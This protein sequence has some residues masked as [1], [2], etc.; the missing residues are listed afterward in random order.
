MEENNC[1]RGAQSR[2]PLVG[3]GDQN[4]IRKEALAAGR[5]APGLQAHSSMRKCLDNSWPDASHFQHLVLSFPNRDGKG[6]SAPASSF[7]S[8]TQRAPILPGAYPK[9]AL[10][11]HL[12]AH[13]SCR[14]T[15]PAPAAQ[16]RS[17]V[18][19]KACELVVIEALGSVGGTDARC[20]R[21]PPSSV[22]YALRSEERRVG[23]ECRSRW[24]PY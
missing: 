20:S 2:L 15:G 13:R 12:A 18:S 10:H 1:N 19:R 8:Q 23:K 17:A 7:A 21:S 16:A 4:L 3:S 22:S 11:G 24:A 6:V 5:F 14:T 9:N